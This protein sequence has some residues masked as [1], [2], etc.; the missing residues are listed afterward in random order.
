MVETQS[1]PVVGER[2]GEDQGFALPSG[3][4]LWESVNL[5]QRH[6]GA[7]SVCFLSQVGWERA[8]AASLDERG[9]GGE[10]QPRH[11]AADRSP[12][13]PLL[14]AGPHVLCFH[15]VHRPGWAPAKSSLSGEGQAGAVP[16]SAEAAAK[17]IRAVLRKAGGLGRR[18]AGTQ[19]PASCPG[20]EMRGRTTSQLLRA[21]K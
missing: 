11:R 20:V 7:G 10:P 15:H 18:L 8:A 16:G 6:E 1:G 19:V 17:N 4:F 21:V 2:E 9:P 5:S 13:G 3:S 12:A 14:P